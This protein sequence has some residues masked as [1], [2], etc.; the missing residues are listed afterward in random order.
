LAAARA[1]KKHF[2]SLLSANQKTKIVLKF[3]I[4]YIYKKRLEIKMER[5]NS[6]NNGNPETTDQSSILPTSN[7]QGM[8]NDSL[9]HAVPAI[10]DTSTAAANTNLNSFQNVNFVSQ[11]IGPWYHSNDNYTSLCSN[12]EK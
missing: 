1:N 12:L 9:A 10:I 11:K 5:Y 7:A 3:L 2:F 8:G 6:P 4:H